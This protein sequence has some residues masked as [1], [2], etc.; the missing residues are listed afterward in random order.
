[1]PPRV[2]AA[3]GAHAGA[4]SPPSRAARP[5][6]HATAIC[7]TPAGNS[8]PVHYAGVGATAAGAGRG[9]VTFTQSLRPSLRIIL[10][11]PARLPIP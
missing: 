1:M 8:H 9:T 11:L 2:A 10:N 5:L 6:A 3:R 4:D 7:A